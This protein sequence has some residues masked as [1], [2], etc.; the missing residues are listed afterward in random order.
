L[1]I[2]ENVTGGAGT[3]ATAVCV[4]AWHRVIYGCFHNGYA[5]SDFDWMLLSTMFDK[6][7]FDHYKT[8]KV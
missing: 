3:K 7:Y 6:Q 4:D 2:D 5:G 1:F 8:H